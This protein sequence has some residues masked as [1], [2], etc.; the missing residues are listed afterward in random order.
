MFVLLVCTVA[1]TTVAA[2]DDC[3]IGNGKYLQDKKEVNVSR[4]SG[5]WFTVYA[6]PKNVTEFLTCWTS[7]VSM[8]ANGTFNL[9][10]SYYNETTNRRQ[11]TSAIME[12]QMNAF[13]HY[14]PNDPQFNAEYYILGTDYDQFVIYGGC[15]PDWPALRKVTWVEFRTKE[16]SPSAKEAAENALQ[17]Q[18]LDLSEYTDFCPDKS[19]Y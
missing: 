17:E 15:P 19:K 18:G 4:L 13:H 3:V 10:Y 6:N 7:D 2:Q 1:L 5:E 8:N 12:H 11:V 16:P 14:H 9:Y